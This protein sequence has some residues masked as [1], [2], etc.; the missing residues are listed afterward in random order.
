MNREREEKKKRCVNERN[1]TAAS[2]NSGPP[3]LVSRNVLK[4]HVPCAKVP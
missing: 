2:E 4:I 1:R 3:V